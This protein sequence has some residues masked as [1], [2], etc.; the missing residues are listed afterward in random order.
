MLYAY[1]SAGY[2]ADI[3]RFGYGLTLNQLTV[4]DPNGDGGDTIALGYLNFFY[5]GKL[6]RDTQ[7]YAEFSHIESEIT[8][9]GGTIG[10][11]VS[12][13]GFRAML[14]E[15]L[16]LSATLKPWVGAGLGVYQQEFTRRHTVD[17][18]GFLTGTFPNRD[19][20]QFVLSFDAMHEWAF[21]DAIDIALRLKYDLGFNDGVDGLS[22]S[23]ILLY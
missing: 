18:G 11:D 19:V 2:A 16:R 21:N 4:D 7:Y 14:Q 10:Q 6:W 5:V 12:S 15:R 8:A 9:S 17:G 13:T 3:G 23:V 1:S 22:A 20:T